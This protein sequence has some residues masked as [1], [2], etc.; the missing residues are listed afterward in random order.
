MQLATIWVVL[1]SGISG[2]IET[3]IAEIA[4]SCHN[5]IACGVYNLYHH[6]DY[7]NKLNTLFFTFYSTVGKKLSKRELIRL[8]R[9][10][11][12]LLMVQLN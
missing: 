10:Y 9:K 12:Y 5:I 6:L 3:S 4:F 7:I 1:P 11:E 2:V 8:Q